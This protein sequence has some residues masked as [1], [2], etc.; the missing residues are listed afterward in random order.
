[1]NQ[2][3]FSQRTATNDIHMAQCVVA[4]IIPLQNKSKTF[5]VP[6]DLGLRYWM[7]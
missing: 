5:S 7:Y 1:M 3:D 6:E 2:I 4:F